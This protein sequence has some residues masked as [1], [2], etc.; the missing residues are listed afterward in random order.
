MELPKYPPKTVHV[1]RNPNP[2]LFS[3]NTAFRY[4]SKSKFLSS[5]LRITRNQCQRVLC[6]PFWILK[7]ASLATVFGVSEKND[8]RIRENPVHTTIAL[9]WVD[10]LVVFFLC[11]VDQTLLVFVLAVGGRDLRCSRKGGL[12]VEAVEDTG[13]KG[14]VSENLSYPSQRMLFPCLSSSP[15]FNMHRRQRQPVS[16][17][18]L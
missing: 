18:T 7:G 15:S 12:V 10:L 2:Y 4:F 5:G 11:L 13:S 17:D 9:W 1:H 3:A 14:R 8:S 16:S 6:C